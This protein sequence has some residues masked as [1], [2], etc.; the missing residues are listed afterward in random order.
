MKKISKP[1]NNIEIILKNCIESIQNSRKGRI[2]QVKDTIVKKTTEYDSLA[3]SGQLYT[4]P[5]HD[6][7]DSIATK[8][9][10]EALYTQKFV[11]KNQLNR[12]IYDKLILLAPNGICPYCQQNL[13]KNL[14]HFLPKT[15]YVTYTVTPYNLVPS[16]TDCNKDKSDSVFN[17]FD[18]QPFHPYY[19]D[20]DDYVWLKA[21][22]VEEEP[23][24]FQ[25]YADPPITLSS[26]QISR[27]KY[28]FSEDGLGLNRIYI[29]HAPGLYRT[30][31]H[32]IKILF[33]KGGKA[34]AVERLQENIEDEQ[35]NS[36]NSWKA[37]MY[38]A[39]IDC[40]WYWETYLP[41]LMKKISIS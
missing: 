18:K 11:P 36:Y 26:E 14:D 34:L 41:S 21:K 8:D 35:A 27:I 25:F 37:A 39:M 13:A 30:C 31:F 4:I 28:C 38:Q 6:T 29:S 15:K 24:S 1:E 9:D 5:I 7:V 16:C 23:I 3:T 32:R 10:M 19:D 40:E 12:D 20:F 2:T 17:S 22:L 33:E